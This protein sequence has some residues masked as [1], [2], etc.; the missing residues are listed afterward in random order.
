MYDRVMRLFAI[1]ALVLFSSVMICVVSFAKGKEKVYVSLDNYAT[2]DENSIL[3][4]DSKESLKVHIFNSEEADLIIPIF[5]TLGEKDIMVESDYQKHTMYITIQNMPRAYFADHY[6]TASDGFVIESYCDYTEKQATIEI[7]LNGLYENE[8]VF[9]NGMLMITFFKPKVLA[10]KIVLINISEDNAIDFNQ[11]EQTEQTEQT[12][13][14][15]QTDQTEQMEKAE[16]F[17]EK[18][19]TLEVAKRVRSLFLNSDIKVYIL[20]SKDE[21]LLLEERIVFA[22]ELNP[23]ITVIIDIEKGR[24]SFENGIAAYYNEEYFIPF[25][26]NEQ[27]AD[28]IE[29]Y[30][31]KETEANVLGIFPESREESLLYHLEMPAAR[32][33]IGYSTNEVE[34]SLFSEDEYLNKIA[35]GIYNGILKSYEV[36]EETEVK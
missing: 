25:F 6:I 19:V 9:K 7:K 4:L 3:T 12:D 21:N 14:T 31:L 32:I 10:D 13:Q 20:R 22:E 29:Y 30:T 18:A 28:H 26:G 16:E 23:D 5:E 17:N 27:L 8:I 35:L 36:M 34:K 24:D 15:D 11:T 2:A 1:V 33:A